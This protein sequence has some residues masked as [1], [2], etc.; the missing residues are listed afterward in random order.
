MP[1]SLLANSFWQLEQDRCRTTPEAR[2][3]RPV[4][5]TS[6]PGRGLS[7]LQRLLVSF[8]QA[9]LLDLYHLVGEGLEQIDLA[10]PG[11]SPAS[12]QTRV[13]RYTMGTPSLKHGRDHAPSPVPMRASGRQGDVGAL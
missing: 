5:I 10:L 8:R 13:D 2:D 9:A 3:P 4:L 6:A 1:C 7:L 12:G 11:V